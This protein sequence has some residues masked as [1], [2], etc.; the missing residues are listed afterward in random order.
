ML[1]EGQRGFCYVRQNCGGKMVLTTYGRSSGFAVDP[2][3]KKPLNHYL[4]GTPVLSFG[5]AGC[6]LGCAFCQNWH[7]SK[8]QEDDCLAVQAS[9]RGIAAAARDYHC[10]SIACT[11]NDPVVF[12]E[13]ARDVCSAVHSTGL[14]AVAVTAGYVTKEAREAFFDCFDAANVDLKAFTKDFY[15][16]LCKGKLDPVLETLQYLQKSKA[17]WFEITTLLIPGKN[18]SAEEVQAMCEWIATELGP[19][20]PLHFTAYH[21]D[22]LLQLPPTPKSTLLRSR[23]IAIKCGLKY[24][25]VGNV[26]STAEQSTWCHNCHRCLIERTTYDV[27]AF[28]IAAEPSGE[29]RCSF[30][31]TVIPGVFSTVWKPVIISKRWGV[32]RNRPFRADMRR[33]SHL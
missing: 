16:D 2:I 17:T 28:H 32:G 14:K 30:C 31:R 15:R 8:A 3:E 6:N 9:P 18:D 19:H 26:D 20:V 13:Y 11:Y 5:T 24:V 25:Y 7:I 22:Y 29:G 4:P 21:P 27:S 23:D 10:P 33:Y 12:F 1:K